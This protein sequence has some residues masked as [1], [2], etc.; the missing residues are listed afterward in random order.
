MT[1]AAA[2]LTSEGVVLGADSTTT[3]TGTSKA[4]SGP[5]G[6]LQLLEHA[7]KVFEVGSEKSRLGVCTWG[8][9]NLGPVS[10]RT[11][12]ARLADQVDPKSTTVDEAA[13]KLK[14]IA[15]P[16]AAAHKAGFVGYF[17]G[18]WNP[19]TREP[20]C[21]QIQIPAN[22]QPVVLPLGVGD[23]NF[24]GNPEFFG[25]A[26]HGYAPDLPKLLAPRLKELLDETVPANYDDAFSQAFRETAGK[27]VARYYKD[28]PIR[29]AIDFVYSYLHISIK[30]LKFRFGAPGC[31]G[32]LEIAFITSD[33]WFRW[34]RHKGF[35][36]A[37]REYEDDS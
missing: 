5:S 29:E 26:F 1:I 24:A 36:S 30:A 28:L 37:L 32:P 8:A 3:V 27:L 13:N 7:Q 33:R 19:G 2:Y 35:T 11:V 23:C 14:D 15:S 4:S 9:G 12:V 22:K 6:V 25:R 34:A 10:H 31:G 21:Y 17:L 20:A 18:G 16:L